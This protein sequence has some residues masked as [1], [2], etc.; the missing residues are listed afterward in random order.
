M[1]AQQMF[2]QMS[3]MPQ[4]SAW[5]YLRYANVISRNII[6]LFKIPLSGINSIIEIS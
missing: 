4:V 2:V 6:A 1:D 3:K 5:N